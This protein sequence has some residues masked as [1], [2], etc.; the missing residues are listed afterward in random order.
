[1]HKQSKKEQN[2]EFILCCLV[3]LAWGL[4]FSVVNISKDI[5]LM[6]TNFSFARQFQLMIALWVGFGS[7]WQLPL[8]VLEPTRLESVH[9]L[10]ML[11]L[12]HMHINSVISRRQCF[13]GGIH[14]PFSFCLLFCTVP[15]A[16]E[17]RLR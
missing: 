3:L 13:C 14:P 17:E 9:L 7:P 16:L 5:P 15:W 1:M 8:S 11:Q 6:I 2:T 4:L 10:P 12:S